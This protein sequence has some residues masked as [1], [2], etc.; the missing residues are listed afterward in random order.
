MLRFLNLIFRRWREHKKAVPDI[1]GGEVASLLA[2]T[3]AGDRPFMAGRGGWME[4]YGAGLWLSGASL[5]KTL[6][7]KLH[8]HAGI[9]PATAQQLQEF[10]GVYLEALASADLLGLMQSPYE[11]WLLNKART[12]ARLCRL[13][14]LE[15]YFAADPWSAALLGKRVLVVHPFSESILSQYR[16]HRPRLFADPRVLPEFEL[17]I[18]KAPQT[19]C[20]ATEGFCSWNEAL[21]DLQQ[22]VSSKYFDVALVGCGAYGLPLAAFIKNS[23]RKPVVHLG[24]ATQLLFGV[25]GGR[26]RNHPDFSK[27]MNEWWQSPVES[28]RPKG[29]E[30]IEEGCYW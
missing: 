25:S 30:K 19:M 21:D 23:L 7:G 22:R 1:S 28:E 11:G 3:A 8:Q 9:F 20:G 26:W 29:W 2:R 6:L 15:P 12:R 27:L 17:S 5:D 24:G 18:V 4:S 13:G 10:S 16:E 14:A